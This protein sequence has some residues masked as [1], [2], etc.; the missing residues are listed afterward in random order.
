MEDS[1][2]ITPR[3]M[4]FLRALTAMAWADGVLESAEVSMMTEH[5]VHL[6]THSE[7]IP[8]MLQTQIQE[9]LH[10]NIP[11][12]ETLPRLQDPQEREL[13]LK[14]AYIVIHVSRRAPGESCVNPEETQ[15]Y[16][17]LIQQLSL[18]PTT[19]Q[20][21]EQEAANSLSLEAVLGEISEICN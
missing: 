2:L 12:A 3:Q 15:A 17:L 5:L 4:N 20:R 8:P 9:F 16:A 18:D 14:L 13:L 11:L 1:P 6:F 19:V 21:V 7:D 10:Q